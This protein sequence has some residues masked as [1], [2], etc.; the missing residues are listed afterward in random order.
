MVFVRHRVRCGRRSRTPL[1]RS[2][3]WFTKMH[4]SML[5]FLG[6]R[7]PLQPEKGREGIATVTLSSGA[8]VSGEAGLSASYQLSAVIVVKKWRRQRCTEGDRVLG[9]KNTTE[10]RIRTPGSRQNNCMVKIK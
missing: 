2:A 6:A 10:R 3:C 8:Y 4:K 5:A 7:V 9:S 1:Q